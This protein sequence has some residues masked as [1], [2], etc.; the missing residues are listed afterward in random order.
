MRKPKNNLSRMVEET[1][2]D[3]PK[4]RDDDI[5]LTQAIWWRYYRHLL[6]ERKDGDSIEYLVNVKY[7][8]ELPREDHIKRYRARFQ[9]ENRIYLPTNKEV[10]KQRRWSENQWTLAMR[11]SIYDNK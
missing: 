11:D 1:L 8:K 5:L 10:A 2:R 3:Y 6:E 4:T 7:I 9:N